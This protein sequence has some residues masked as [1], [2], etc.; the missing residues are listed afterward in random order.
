MG[1]TAAAETAQAAGGGAGPGGKGR[2]RGGAAKAGLETAGSNR[3]TAVV[4]PSAGRR[5]RIPL[6][7]QAG[8]LPP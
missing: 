8:A 7:A 1:N 4:A 2:S 5:Q 6:P 3:S